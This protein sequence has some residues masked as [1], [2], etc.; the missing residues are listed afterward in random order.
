MYLKMQFFFQTFLSFIRR[1]DD[2]AVQLFGA[3]FSL[4]DNVNGDVPMGVNYILSIV[5]ILLPKSVLYA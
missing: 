2:V 4:Y 5:D 1:L 3:S